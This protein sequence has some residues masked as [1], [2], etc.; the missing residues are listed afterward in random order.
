M[1]PFQQSAGMVC[2]SLYWCTDTWYVGAYQYFDEEEK[3]SEEEGMVEEQ[4]RKKEK[5][6]RKKKKVEEV[7]KCSSNIT[8]AKRQWRGLWHRMREEG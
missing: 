5:G 8:A 3:E 2:T 1:D 4:R 6:R 7:K